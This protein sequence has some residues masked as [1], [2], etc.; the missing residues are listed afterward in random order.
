M[1]IFALFFMIFTPRPSAKS[2]SRW[3]PANN[4]APIPL[5]AY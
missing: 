3:V 4:P 2:M 1:A 5:T